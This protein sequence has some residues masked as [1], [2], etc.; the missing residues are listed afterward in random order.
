MSPFRVSAVILNAL[1]QYCPT[2][3]CSNKGP[4]GPIIALMHYTIFII[5][6]T[7]IL[8]GVN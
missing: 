8:K 6:L 1:V 3:R 2:C 4:I 7:L 5:A